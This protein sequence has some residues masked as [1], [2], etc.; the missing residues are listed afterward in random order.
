DIVQ[1]NVSRAANGNRADEIICIIQSDIIAGASGERGRAAYAQDTAIGD[2]A[3]CGDIQVPVNRET[4]NV[5]ST[6]VAHRDV[7]QI[8][9]AARNEIDRA[10]KSISGI[11]KEDRSARN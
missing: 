11:T 2:C 6:V 4:K 8:A 3:I 10:T 7:E 1:G 5:E 9:D